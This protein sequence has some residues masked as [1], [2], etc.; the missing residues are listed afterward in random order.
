ME[1]IKQNEPSYLN[2]LATIKDK[3]EDFYYTINYHLN[4]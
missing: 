2:W 3:D 1:E 4:K